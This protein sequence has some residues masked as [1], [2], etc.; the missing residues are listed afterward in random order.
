M[1]TLI[2]DGF[3][4]NPADW[5]KDIAKKLA[6]YDGIHFLTDQHWKVIFY[7]RDYYNDFQSVP[8]IFKI[9]SATGLTTMEIC[10]LFSKDTIRSACRI[11][12]LP[13]TTKNFINFNV[14]GF[15]V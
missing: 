7:I 9:C 3:L 11:A 1:T 14:R 2:K 15:E 5:N 6:E 8:P 12:G 4:L 13:R 10:S